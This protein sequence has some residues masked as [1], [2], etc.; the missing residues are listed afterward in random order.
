MK[1]GVPTH[2]RSGSLLP[3]RY[4][5]LMKTWEN[6]LSFDRSDIA[7]YRL[8]VLKFWEKYGRRATEAAFGVKTSTLY[9]WRARLTHAQGKLL[10][11]VPQSTTPKH[12]RAMVVEPPLLAFI[13]SVREEY[14]NVGKEALHP[15]LTAYAQSLGLPSYGKTKI[16]KLITR[17]HYFFEGRKVVK[18]RISRT[19]RVKRSPK[20]TTPGYIEL[21]CIT[22]YVEGKRKYFVTGIDV[23][24]KLASAKC[25][26]H[27]NSKETRDF[28]VAWQHQLPY[29][30]HTIQTDNGSEFLANFHSYL[31]QASITHAFTYPRSPKVNGFIERFN[32]TIQNHYVNR[33]SDLWTD[34]E[35]KATLKLE[36]FLY[37]YNEVRPHQSLKCLTP[38][39]FT[40]QYSNMYAS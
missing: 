20:L 17:Y 10:S 4:A 27:L 24:T 28:L 1:V 34:Q 40:S 39:Q 3:L 18:R 13:R 29:R 9:V 16:G 33:C 2:V 8:H 22:V 37:W 38:A 32:W 25:I 31:E 6:A 26:A 5:S 19:N 35:E 15:L 21:D 23:F 7:K 36:R 12:T 30:I 11:L 14:G